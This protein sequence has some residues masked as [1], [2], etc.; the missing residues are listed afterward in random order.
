[1]FIGISIW[2]EKVAAD[3]SILLDFHLSET[4][5]PSSTGFHHHHHH[6]YKH[7]YDR[8]LYFWALKLHL[9]ISCGCLCHWHL[10]HNTVVSHLVYVYS[11]VFV[12]CFIPLS[13]DDE[14]E[15][16]SAQ[17]Q[18]AYHKWKEFQLY[19]IVLFIRWS[20]HAVHAH[21]LCVFV[22]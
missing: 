21:V 10:T 1:M 3:G 19:F 2:F 20:M 22:E 14:N 17:A 6:Y 12:I 7:T 9:P 16:R 11:L 13:F 15:N 5:N 18:S 8:W 4:I